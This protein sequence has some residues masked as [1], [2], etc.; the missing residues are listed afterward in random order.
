MVAVT[1]AENFVPVTSATEIEVNLS[2]A[3]H[4][5]R[6]A[7][8]LHA[9]QEQVGYRPLEN[10]SREKFL[11]FSDSLGGIPYLDL[12]KDECFLKSI[13]SK[14]Y[15]KFIL[16]LASIFY[17]CELDCHTFQSC[18][19]NGIRNLLNCESAEGEKRV[20]FGQL[21]ITQNSQDIC[22]SLLHT[23]LDLTR[24]GSGKM[25]F[26]SQ[27]MIVIHT[28]YRLNSQKM[29]EDAEMLA[30]LDAISME[31]WVK[32]MASIRD[33]RLEPCDAFMSVIDSPGV[34]EK[35]K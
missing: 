28:V 6:L 20:F 25:C 1:S 8:L 11:N 10:N 35:F 29:M 16:E 31:Q 13:R 24:D 27:K 34:A 32:D 7:S 18:I 23:S 14:D 9:V 22:V 19:K 2:R 15:P 3:N 33:S 30:H 17:A 12:V 4:V 26:A 5:N 21:I